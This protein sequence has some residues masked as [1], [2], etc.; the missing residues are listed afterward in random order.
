MN[1]LG[2]FLILL[3]LFLQVMMHDSSR[4]IFLPRR[5]VIYCIKQQFNMLN[6]Y[7]SV[8]VIDLFMVYV[9]MQSIAQVTE[10]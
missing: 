9:T 4:D 8:R 3:F 2:Y 6:K 7:V 5:E 10:E 1:A